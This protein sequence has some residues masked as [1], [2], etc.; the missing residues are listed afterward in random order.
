[1]HLGG[2]RQRTKFL[3]KEYF[4]GFLYKLNLDGERQC[5]VGQSSLSKD[6]LLEVTSDGSQVP[7]CRPGEWRQAM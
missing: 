4:V 2:E 6:I 1:M 3:M 5:G 7:I